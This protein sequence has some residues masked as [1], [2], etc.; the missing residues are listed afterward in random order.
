MTDSLARTFELLAASPSAHAAEVLQAGLTVEDPAIRGRAAETLLGRTGTRG[1]VEVIRH[2]NR[3]DDSVRATLDRNARQIEPALKYSI[4]HGDENLRRHAHEIARRT[5][6]FD[7]HPVLIRLLDVDDSQVAADAAETLRLLTNRLHERLC[8][9]DGNDNPRTPRSPAYIRNQFLT[10]LDQAATRFADRRRPEVIVEA[11]LILGDPEH[12][13]VKKV[14]WQGP[15]ECRELA[16]R[17][18]LTSTHPG[19]MRLIFASFSR[20]YPHVRAFEA[21]SRRTDPE[22]ICF[23]L[24]SFPTRLSKVQQKNF[25]QVESVAW[26]NR[27]ALGL[28]PIPPALQPALIRFIAAVG[29][30]LDTKLAV[31][32]WLLRNGGP[33]GRLAVADSLG[34]LDDT[35]VQQIV[36]D[37]LA[38]DDASVQVWAT[39]QL[40]AYGG[41]EAFTLLIER[42][43][44]PL[45]EVR[46]AARDELHSFDLDVMLEL[47]DQLEPAICRR[48]GELLLK[49]DSELLERVQAELVGP[50]R[51]RRILVARAM[52]R[53]GLHDRIVEA[54]GWM[55]DDEDAHVRRVAAEILATV[56]SGEADALLRRAADDPSPRVRQA[57]GQA[58]EHRPWSGSLP[59]PGGDEEE[60]R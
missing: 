31:Q 58:L 28:E 38:C 7:L 52:H 56:A 37:G 14:L 5:E 15:A 13:A 29:I 45:E 25:A 47:Y 16:G 49:I 42:L 12:F 21:L 11:V 24:R 50:L 34:S 36:L 17:I 33:E 2:W 6:A 23:L 10:A 20:N 19:V 30:P 39:G 48:A 4:E 51:R 55:L 54:L 40:R 18:L 8:R 46:K 1:H 60:E 44:S 9:K 3:L 57:V 32:E 59:E 35:A 43:E 41:A 26:L 53:M 22:F 27:V